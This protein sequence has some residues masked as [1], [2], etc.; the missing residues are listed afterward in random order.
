MFVQKCTLCDVNDIFLKYLMTSVLEQN[1]TSRRAVRSI[2][3]K[4]Q[5]CR[6]LPDVLSSHLMA[7]SLA[8]E[9]KTGCGRYRYGFKKQSQAY[10]KSL[11]E[12]FSPVE[13]F[14]LVAT[15]S[16]STFHEE[17]SSTHLP[18]S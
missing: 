8:L 11:V 1:N 13:T 6:E 3:R 14:S 5:L 17:R 7:L 10:P 4:N 16:Q 2:L 15:V 9:G 18:N 12:T